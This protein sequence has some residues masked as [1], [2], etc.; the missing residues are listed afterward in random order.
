[1]NYFKTY[2]IKDKKIKY[3]YLIVNILTL[4]LTGLLILFNLFF[5]NFPQ[6]VFWYIVTFFF[7]QLS[8][9]QI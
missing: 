6:W 3:I 5:I 8:L 2:L 9:I 7:L 1:M 4:I